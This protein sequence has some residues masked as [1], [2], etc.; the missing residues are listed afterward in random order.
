M[1]LKIGIKDEPVSE[2]KRL[3][4]VSENH[5]TVDD[6]IDGKLL[7]GGDFEILSAEPSVYRRYSDAIVAEYVGS[8]TY[9]RKEF[10]VG[11]SV[12]LN[13]FLQLI[14]KDE[15]FKIPEIRRELQSQA[16]INIQD[17]F[18]RVKKLEF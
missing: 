18:E 8:G 10:A 3:I 13:D 1:L 14:K 2:T 4:M 6:D 15:L 5:K 12:V 17:E 9:S 7:I 16:Q 11:R